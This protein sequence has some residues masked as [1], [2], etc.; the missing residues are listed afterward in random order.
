MNRLSRILG[1]MALVLLVPWSAS[2]QTVGPSLTKV[3]NKPGFGYTLGYATAWTEESDLSYTAVFT[4]PPEGDGGAVTVA[5]S[6]MKAPVQG[7][8][9]EGAKMV[10]DRYIAELSS[11]N[12]KAVVQTKTPFNYRKP[13][14]SVDGFQ[15]VTDFM[16]GEA[17]LRQWAVFLPRPG[18][19]VVHIWLYTATLD[20]F[21]SHIPTVQAMLNSWTLV[22]DD[23]KP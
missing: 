19:T 11:A 5:I 10:R 23:V 6:N 17:P 4:R 16:A 1:L 13:G 12:P 22:G 18:G 2:A 7:A 15:V 21:D 8:P 9:T 3:F 14:A 20:N